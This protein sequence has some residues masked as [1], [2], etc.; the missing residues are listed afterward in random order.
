[1]VA[2][3]CVA[4]D[5]VVGNLAGRVAASS[6]KECHGITCTNRQDIEPEPEGLDNEDWERN[7]LD[8]FN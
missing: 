6:C 1:M 2:G 4:K 8:I 7:F 3:A 5:V